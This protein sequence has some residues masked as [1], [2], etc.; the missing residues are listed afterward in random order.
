MSARRSWNPFASPRPEVWTVEVAPNADG[1][2]EVWVF[3]TAGFICLC[4][5][6]V[7]IFQLYGGRQGAD[8]EHRAALPGPVPRSAGSEQRIFREMQEGVPRRYACAPRTGAWPTVEALAD[9]GIP[10]FA[11]T[12]STRAGLR[13]E[14]RRDGW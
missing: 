12:R 14:Q 8:A 2:E 3:L 1:D 5:I 10:P 4:V 9:G 7:L 11:P 6:Y 13:W